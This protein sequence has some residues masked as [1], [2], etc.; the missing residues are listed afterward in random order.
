MIFVTVGSQM[1]FD[2][3]VEAVDGWVGQ[4]TREVLAQ[5]GDSQLKP[6]KHALC[7]FNATL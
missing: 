4:T 2:R 7:A 3:L 6:K 1:P 5:I